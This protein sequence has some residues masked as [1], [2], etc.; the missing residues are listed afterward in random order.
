MKILSDNIELNISDPTV[1]IDIGQIPDGVSFVSHRNVTLKA[2]KNS[3]YSYVTGPK[4][5]DKVW[6]HFSKI[7]YDPDAVHSLETNLDK[8]PYP[9]EQLHDTMAYFKAIYD[10][11]GTEA[12]V[13]LMFNFETKEWRTLKVLQL[14]AAHAAVQYIYPSNGPNKKYPLT[15]KIF[16]DEKLKDLQLKVYENYSELTNQGFAIIGTIH[17]HCNFGAFHSGTDNHDEMNFD[18]LH[19]TIGKVNSGWDF[20]QRWMLGTASFKC[21]ITN[22]TKKTLKEITDIPE[23]VI[24]D[25]DLELLVK[26][27]P[28][29][30]VERTVW[31]GHSF[32]S[33]NPDAPSLWNSPNERDA[34]INGPPV[35]MAEEEEDDEEPISNP[36]VFSEH[37][38]TRLVNKETGKY[39]WVENDYYIMSGHFFENFDLAPIQTKFA[40]VYLIN[41]PALNP[42]Y[43]DGDKF[44]TSE[45]KLGKAKKI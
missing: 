29:V 28:P 16:D 19:I 10:K 7:S 13:L 30:Q 26:Q 18:G 45:V 27:A 6:D 31:N 42:S 2:I 14:G 4:D 22:V 3:L 38:H 24:S 43:P 1:A 37:C 11:Y 33:Y 36:P 39:I 15:E 34:Y 40:E 5:E 25:E 17:S 44:K 41:S 20:A 32:R 9:L 8:Y 23:I 21:E 35:E 12:V